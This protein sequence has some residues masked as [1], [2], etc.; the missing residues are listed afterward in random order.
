[1]SSTSLIHGWID[2]SQATVGDV[3]SLLYDFHEMHKGKYVSD[4][5]LE[6]YD[7]SWNYPTL[8]SVDYNTITYG[9]SVGSGTVDYLENVFEMLAHSAIELSGIIFAKLPDSVY[10]QW[11]FAKNE[12]QMVENDYLK[13]PPEYAFKWRTRSLSNSGAIS[14]SGC[15]VRGWF[16]S[17]SPGGIRASLIAQLHEKRVLFESDKERKICEDGWHFSPDL[18]TLDPVT[19]GA[20]IVLSSEAILHNIVKE[21]VLHEDVYNGLVYIS[22]QDGTGNRWIVNG[23]CIHVLDG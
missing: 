3:A 19:F 15:L 6:R 4:Y 5:N 16:E 8:P 11:V 20:R 12:F 10:Q 14:D 7:D 13:H 23:K 21:I 22:R 1:M 17:K 9:A 2:C 18:R